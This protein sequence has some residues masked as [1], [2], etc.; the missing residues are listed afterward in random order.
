MSIDTATELPAVA[1]VIQRLRALLDKAE[2]IKSETTVEPALPV[3]EFVTEIDDLWE[4]LEDEE[5]NFKLNATEVAARKVFNELLAAARIDEPAFVRVWNLLDLTIMCADQAMCEPALTC[6]LIEELLDSQTT[7]DCRTVFDYLESRTARL[8]ARDFQKKHLPF[9]RSCNELLRRLSKAEDAIF[10]G[11]IFFFLFHTFP[12]GDKSSVNLRGEFHVENKTEFDQ[13]ESDGSFYSLFWSLQQDFSEPVRL[14]QPSH[15]DRFKKGLMRTL[16]TFKETPT[17]VQ[18]VNENG[19]RGIKRKRE[20]NDVFSP[21]ETYNPRYLTSRDLFSLELADLGFQRHIMVQGLILL[22]FLLSLSSDAKA[23]LP[24]PKNKPLKY[25][26]TLS[27]GD[28]QWCTETR[29]AITDYMQQVP[30]AAS[31]R[32]YHRMVETILSRDRNWVRWKL[33]SCPSIV[34]E[35]VDVDAQNE[36]WASMRRLSKPRR[37]LPNSTDFSF[38]EG[39]GGGLEPLRAHERYGEPPTE[40]LVNRLKGARLDLEMATE[41][42]AGSLETEIATTSW[43]ILRRLRA[44]DLDKLNKGNPTEVEKLFTHEDEGH[45]DEEAATG[46]S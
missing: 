6:H 32:F 12:L 4:D 8:A 7:T 21:L 17:V 40:E 25:A 10:C 26:Y 3:A 41:E 22:D 44:T 36:A 37:A 19:P 1:Q 43:S 5:A 28:A 2:R 9:L 23:R 35:P 11:R 18:T 46:T 14:F 34:Q 29:K 39:N 38:L 24:E 15:F 30:Y 13:D 33:E 45:E 31:G 42:E 20:D 16:E 27:E